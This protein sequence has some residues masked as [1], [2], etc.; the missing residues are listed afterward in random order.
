MYLIQYLLTRSPIFFTGKLSNC[1]G[2]VGVTINDRLQLEEVFKHDLLILCPSKEFNL[3][4]KVPNKGQLPDKTFDIHLEDSVKSYDLYL[5]QM[6]FE[7][8]R[9]EQQPEALILI[10]PAKGSSA[11]FAVI[12]GIT[13]SVLVV[14]IIAYVYIETSHQRKNACITQE[15]LAVDKNI[16]MEPPNQ[17]H[18]ADTS[19]LSTAHLDQGQVIF[20]GIYIFLRLIYSLVFTFTVFFAI[21]MMIVEGDL[22]WVGKA[23][24]YQKDKYNQ[25]LQLS[26]DLQKYGRDELLRQSELV[27]MKQGACSHYIAELFDGMAYEMDNIT[28]NQH[29][30]EMHGDQSSISFY[31][32]QRADV[33]LKQYKKYLINFKSKYKSTFD[34]TIHSYLSHYRHY[35]KTMYKSDWYSFPQ[36]MF[37]K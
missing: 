1:P 11:F 22:V 15:Q 34:G 5:T 36:K 19:C 17:P 26:A 9:V 35:L 7:Q 10:Q 30:L 3:T 28:A 32:R 25:S 8:Q 37:N 27:T 20:I 23:G 24:E 16:Y 14:F 4:F 6:L 33:L 21:V 13:A 12:G 29:L 2:Y 31:M 18:P